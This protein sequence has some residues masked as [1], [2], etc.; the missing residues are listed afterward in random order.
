MK[1]LNP[2]RMP[3]ISKV[4]AQNDKMMAGWEHSEMKFLQE[5]QN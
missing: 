2:E 5:R 3:T 4:K 1:Y